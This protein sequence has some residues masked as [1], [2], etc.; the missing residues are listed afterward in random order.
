[1]R[2]SGNQGDYRAT[3]SSGTRS[4]AS[5]ILQVKCAA[6]N[7]PVASSATLALTARIAPLVPGTPAM[8]TTTILASIPDASA[9][10]FR[11]VLRQVL[12]NGKRVGVATAPPTESGPHILTGSLVAPASGETVTVEVSIID[13]LAREGAAI[14]ISAVMP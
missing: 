5:P 7:V 13:P 2:S 8:L 4:T 3:G 12:A 11:A 10:T 6:D 1:M 14:T 9:G